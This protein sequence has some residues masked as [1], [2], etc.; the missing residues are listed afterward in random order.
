MLRLSV[1]TQ[2]TVNNYGSVL[3][4]YVTQKIFES[5]GHR[6]EFVDFWRADNLEA[7]RVDRVLQNNSAMKRLRP[8]WASIPP[9]ARLTRWAVGKLLQRN[10][11]NMKRFLEQRVTFSAE[12]Y[13]SAEMLR[14]RP[15]VADVYITG[16][17]QVWNSQ[18]N[19]GVERAYFLDYAPAGKKR[20][21]FAA[22]IGRTALDKEEIPET[23]A[24]LKRYTAISVR[25]QS[26]V[27]LLKSLGIQAQ[28]ILDPTLV[29]DGAWWRRLADYRK[30]PKAPYLLIYQLNVNPQMDAYAEKQPRE[31]AGILSGSVIIIRTNGKLAAA[32][33]V[34]PFRS[35]S[36]FLTRRPAA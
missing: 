10:Q 3:Q 35:F 5:M 33:S 18:Y 8:L 15:P 31:R 16:S 22:S 21:S 32:C 29:L 26:G 11:R 23:V 34:P 14:R 7:A 17:D 19:H 12:K 9:A 36:A 6:V 1:I 25:E 2:H 24:L 20:I 30:C 27:D 4:T 28:R 13:L